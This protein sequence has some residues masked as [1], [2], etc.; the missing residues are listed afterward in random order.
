MGF[1][2]RF[3]FVIFDNKLPF[4]INFVKFSFS[5]VFSLFLHVFFKF[6]ILINTIRIIFFIYVILRT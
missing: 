6:D 4:I 1:L 2:K 5:E 3:F